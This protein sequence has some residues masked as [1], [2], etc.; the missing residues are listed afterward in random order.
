MRTAFTIAG[1]AVKGL[2]GLFSAT[3]GLGIGLVRFWAARPILEDAIEC[4]TCGSA[5]ALLGLW[6]C[7]CGYRFYG[8]YFRRCDACGEL[9]GFI[10]CPSCGASTMNPTLFG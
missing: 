9:P 6:E 8:W 2:A 1:L 10:D 4:G 7:H 3:I 5:I